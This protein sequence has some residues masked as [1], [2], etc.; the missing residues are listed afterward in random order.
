MLE[1][2]HALNADD[3]GL[4]KTVQTIDCFNTLKAGKIFIC[5][6]SSAKYY[7]RAMLWEWLRVP[8]HNIQIIDTGKDVIDPSV[9]IVIVNYDLIIKDSIFNQ[10]RKMK[11]EVG[12]CDEA[13]Y[14]QSLD[15]Q[16]TQRILGNLG[17]I[18]NC[19]Y[20]F[21][22]SATPLHKPKHLYP[23]LHTLANDLLTPYNSYRDF[24]FRFCDGY[25]DFYSGEVVA[26]GASNLEDLKQRLQKFMIRRTEDHNRPPCQ[27]RVVP[28]KPN[29]AIKKL[30][31]IEQRF[32][33]ETKKQAV[34]FES[35]GE[36]AVH[37]KEV[38]LAK[39][40][41]C[42]QFIKDLLIDIP[43]LVVFAYHR[44][45][46]KALKEAL[47]PYGVA[48]VIGGMSARK[49]YFEVSEFIDH[50]EIRI[51]LGQVLAA[52]ES[53]DGLQKVCNHAVFVE[54]SYVPKDIKQPIGRLRRM[55]QMS[56]YVYVDFLAVEGTIDY[57]VLNS[58]IRKQKVIDYLMGENG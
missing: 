25:I 19:T 33:E 58:I 6:L 47:T 43:K 53:I 8:Y 11:F 48:M 54:S 57:S 52:G 1:H 20:K 51:F 32:D 12:V 5:C 35:Q 34:V 17:I 41:E 45:V 4:G 14:L 38:G 23:M 39:L 29:A 10:I 16:R 13:H 21:M 36:L 44:D 56:K 2:V 9:D 55:G 49:K 7:W 46:M 37:R 31:K 40:P 26:D 30:I 28:L 42:V 24:A 27:F 15:A 3:S 50:K 22:L 18:R